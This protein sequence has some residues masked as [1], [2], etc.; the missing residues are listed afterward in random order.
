MFEASPSLQSASCSTDSIEHP[1]SA[2]AAPAFPRSLAHLAVPS[3]DSAVKCG[4]SFLLLLECKPWACWSP[5]AV[6]AA[7]STVPS[8]R[9]EELQ[10]ARSVF[11]VDPSAGSY[12]EANWHVCLEL[13]SA[14]HGT[15]TDSVMWTFSQTCVHEAAAEKQE[16]DICK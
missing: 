10:A 11:S 7:A 16:G 4:H 2:L 3:P 5:F 12:L 9:P 6:L 8:I 14:S 15:G 1:H 13:V